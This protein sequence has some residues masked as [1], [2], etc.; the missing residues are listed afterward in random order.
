LASID[1][2]SLADK[3]YQHLELVPLLVEIASD[4]YSE[5]GTITHALIRQKGWRFFSTSIR[6]DYPGG[7]RALERRMREVRHYTRLGA[8]DRLSLSPKSV[9]AMIA[10]AY[11]RQFLE[12]A[13]LQKSTE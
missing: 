7:M 8:H 2:V 13:N 6:S 5:F 1:T 11:L 12:P 4:F 3:Q 10:N 9:N